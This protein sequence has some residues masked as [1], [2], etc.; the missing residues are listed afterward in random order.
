MLWVFILLG[1]YWASWIFSLVPVI[2]FGKYS[3]II[4]SN[5]SFVPFFLLLLVFLLTYVVH[6]VVVLWFL[7]ISFNFFIFFFFFYIP[8]ID[9]S[10]NIYSS[11]LVLLS[12]IPSLL[13]SFSNFCFSVFDFYH[14]LLF[15]SSFHLSAYIMHVILCC[16]LILLEPF[17][18]INQSS[19]KF[20]VW[21]F[22]NFCLTW[23]WF[24]LVCRFRLYIL[25]FQFVPY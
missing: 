18:Y 4:T 24:W 2:N 21:E 19:F 14:F 12:I 15:S 8:V 25:S 3:A 20:P 22:Q 9:V 1:V 10:T 7:D 13:M 23:I 5:V 11:S 17:P 6:F 16:L